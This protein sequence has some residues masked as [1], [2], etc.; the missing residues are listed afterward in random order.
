M[1]RYKGFSAINIAGLMIG[2]VCCLLICLYVFDELSYDRWNP[3]ADRI[4]RINSD[5]KFGERDYVMCLTADPMGPVMAKDNPQ[6]EKQVRIHNYYATVV[7]KG[8]D[9]IPQGN[10]LYADSTLF[11][12]FPFKVLQGDAKT[13]LAAPGTIVLTESMA[14]KYF[15]NANASVVGQTLLIDNY[16]LVRVTAVIEDLPSN[17]HFYAEGF[18]SMASF[19]NSRENAWGSHNFHTYLLLRDGVDANSFFPRAE[20]NYVKTYLYPWIQK[21][22]GMTFDD[23]KKSGNFLKYSI[24][25]LKDIHLHS[26]REGE[27]KP[28]GSIQYVW[29]FSAV[30][31]FIL[32]IACINFM[33]LTTAQ[34]SKRSK[35]VGIRKVLGSDQAALIKQFLAESFLTVLIALILAIGMMAV[36]LPAFNEIANKELSFF[37]IF[38]PPLLFMILALPFVVGALAGSYPAFFLSRFQPLKVLKSNTGG[39]HGTG[40]K[41]RSVLVVFQFTMSI[42]LLSSTV[43]IYKQLG[44]I[45]NTKLGFQREQRIIVQNLGTLNQNKLATLKE[46]FAK[47]PGVINASISGFLPVSSN[48]T[49]TIFYKGNGNNKETPVSMQHWFAD[50]DYMKTMGMEL[51]SGRYFEP[52]S[53]GNDSVGMVL[54]EE[55]VKKFGFKSNEEALGKDITE[56]VDMDAQK[57]AT[58]HVIGVM[59]NFHFESLRQTIGALSIKLSGDGN[60]ITLHVSPQKDMPGLVKQLEDVFKQQVP[61]EMFSYAF[62]DESYNNMYRAETRVG[63]IALVF[64]AL[65][66]FIACIGLLGLI[67]FVV[68]Q[69]NKEIGIRKVLGAST[70]SVVT[71]LSKD[72]IKLV[73][74]AIVIA[75]PLAWYLMSS[76]LKDFAFSIQLHWWL[77][78]FAGGVAVFIALLTVGLQSLKAALTNPIQ[79][80]KS[81]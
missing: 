52:A 68:Q 53:F 7:R 24:I 62:M 50:A 65:A 63:R 27:L 14:K 43:I 38:Q 71:L 11:D 17:M 21:T 78:A 23:L 39:K 79:S 69:R 26:N 22:L 36:V 3:K 5:I 80:L 61:H 15:G 4:Y 35:E 46:S 12:V 10:L 19:Q 47:V 30:A 66:I 81:E 51:A 28:S 70:V 76:W 20:Q 6:I 44:Y 33:N 16:N 31:L 59:K 77:F 45:Q 60:R 58:F 74:V 64:A 1:W 73:I 34:S 18:V 8:E 2:L 40:G 49:N 42:I 48:R 29:V 56:Y 13:A 55:A 25:P 72:F 41:L 67:A 9:N 32:M 75:T 37:T 54:N 57:F